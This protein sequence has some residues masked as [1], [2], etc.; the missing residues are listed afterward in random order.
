MDEVKITSIC[1]MGSAFLCSGSDVGILYSTDGDTWYQS[2][3]DDGDFR[4]GKVD[5]YTENIACA[6]RIED[7]KKF[8]SLNGK[9][10][11]PEEDLTWDIKIKDPYINSEDKISKRK[12]SEVINER[13]KMRIKE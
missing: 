11:I 12:I 2:N 6:I 5:K 1:I 13:L 7:D 10:W 4:I 9:Y 3:L 8:Y